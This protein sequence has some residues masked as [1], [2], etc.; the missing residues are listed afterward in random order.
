MS[1]DQNKSQN[2]D[3]EKNKNPVDKAFNKIT[4]KAMQEVDKKIDGKVDEYIKAKKLLDG[5]LSEITDLEAEKTNV[6]N[7]YK[8]LRKGLPV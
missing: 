4:D 3:K 7:E 5:I 8:A 2:Q 1:D 6:I